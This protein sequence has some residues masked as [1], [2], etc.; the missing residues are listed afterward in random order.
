VRTV[1]SP[2][3][4]NLAV[5]EVA[6]RYITANKKRIDIRGPVFTTVAAEFS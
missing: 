5:D 1:K 3:D 6:Q 2:G 4:I